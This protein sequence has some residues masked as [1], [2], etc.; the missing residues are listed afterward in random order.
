M[1]QALSE[2]SSNAVTAL[3]SV[4][5]EEP[6]ATQFDD[7]WAELST[8]LEQVNPAVDDHWHEETLQYAYCCVCSAS[9]L[10]HSRTPS[11][12]VSLR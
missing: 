7:F 3:Q 4:M 1:Y 12:V 9:L 2:D 8:F 5:D 6:T 10:G 11:T